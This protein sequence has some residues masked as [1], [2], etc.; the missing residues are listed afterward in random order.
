MDPYKNID[1]KIQTLFSSFHRKMSRRNFVYKFAMGV[2]ASI[3]AML[4]RPI[5]GLETAF[6]H[7]TPCNPPHGQFCSGCTSSGGCPTNYVTCTTK[8]AP[9]SC[10]GWCP[11]DSG[12]WYSEGGSS[13]HICR[14]CQIT[15]FGPPDSP[16]HTFCSKGATISNKYILC[17]CRGDTHH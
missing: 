10:P 11:Y 4:I 2:T 17:G 5:G 15:L 14:D 16:S 1:Q 13:G 6:A 8:N 12:F 3:A 9:S 7:G